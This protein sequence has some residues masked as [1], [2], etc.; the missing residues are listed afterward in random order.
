M[1]WSTTSRS[2]D[3]LENVPID[4]ICRRQ[5]LDLVCA[6]QLAILALELLQ[7]CPFVRR[8][9]GRW[10]MSRSAWAPPVPTD[11]GWSSI[12]EFEGARP[13]ERC[14][15]KAEVTR[16]AMSRENPADRL[17]ALYTS[18]VHDV[19]RAMGRDRFVLPPEIR[20]LDPATRV[21]GAAWTVSGRVDETRSAHDTLL[22]WTGVLSEAPAGSVVICQPNNYWIALMGELSAAALRLRGV[23]GYVVDDC[24]QRQALVDAGFPTFCRGATP[25]DIVCRWMPDA[26]GAPITIGDVTIATGDYVLGDRRCRDESPGDRR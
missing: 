13:L 22:A 21:A 5:A 6:S 9:A 17:E 16:L 11:P 23:R 24:P 8:E 20:S 4:R 25:K 15:Y 10:P 1:R 26:L 12:Q 2:S 3:P 7:S 14:P 18:A 19:M